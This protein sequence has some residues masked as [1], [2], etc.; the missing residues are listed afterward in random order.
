MKGIVI[1]TTILAAAAAIAV[2]AAADVAVSGSGTVKVS[3]QT[4]GTYSMVQIPLGA[5]CDVQVGHGRA[6]VTINLNDRG[7][8]LSLSGRLGTT[9]NLATMRAHRGRTPAFVWYF[10]P[11]RSPRL[12]PTWA[13]GFVEYD[14]YHGATTVQF[15]AAGTLTLS[16]DGTSGSL[17]ATLI[18]EAGQRT[19]TTPGHGNTIHLTAHWRC[20]LRRAHD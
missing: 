3:G 2:P 15:K 5:E 19:T 1:T 4:N 20:S 7:N 17:N 9:T 14:T 13:N 6:G 18:R 11:N 8:T 10:G 12:T 16:S